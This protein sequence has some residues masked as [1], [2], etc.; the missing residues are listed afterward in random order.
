ML[1]SKWGMGGPHGL[2]KRKVQHYYNGEF[3]DKAIQN[4]GWWGLSGPH[5]LFK[6]SSDFLEEEKRGTAFS[7]GINPRKIIYFFTGLGKRSSMGQYS[8]GLGKRG[9]Q[10]SFGLGK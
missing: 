9:H 10:F 1:L 7:F 4:Y 3:D 2:F 5:G 8:F 6:K